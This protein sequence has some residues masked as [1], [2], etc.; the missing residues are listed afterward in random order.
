VFIT[1]VEDRGSCLKLDED[2]AWIN[3]DSETGRFVNIA[4]RQRNLR[5][6]CQRCATFCC[7]LGG[8]SLSANDTEQIRKEGYNM[9][10]FLEQST[11]SGRKG[12]QVMSNVLKSRQDG[13]C[14]FLRLDLGKGWHEC[15][16]YDLRP[17]LCR[18]YPFDFRMISPTSL[19]LKLIPCCRGLNSPAGQ[20][21]DEEFIIRCLRN[22]IIDVLRNN[23]L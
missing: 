16:I 15:S 1:Q 20:L 2:V 7:R 17:A 4:M 12:P 19:R 9:K 10:D 13:S 22:P 18:L 21:V 5:F 14:I 23:L 3:L 11:R 8:P 6:E